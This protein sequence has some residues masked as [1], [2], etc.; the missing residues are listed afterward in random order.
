M[1]KK[2]PR[3][4]SDQQSNDKCTTTENYFQRE[5]SPKTVLVQNGAPNNGLIQSQ[6]AKVP[7]ETYNY[8]RKSNNSIIRGAKIPGHN[9]GCHGYADQRDALSK[10]CICNV[11]K[12]LGF[13][14]CH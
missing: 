13:G 8:G 14:N 12:C 5:S 1:V 9:R 3:K 2:M 4:W 10:A 11:T 6:I 7:Q